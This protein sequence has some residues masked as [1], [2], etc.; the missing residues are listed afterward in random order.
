MK[1]LNDSDVKNVKPNAVQVR[2][3]MLVTKG[4]GTM[5]TKEDPK[6]HILSVSYNLLPTTITI[7]DAFGSLMKKDAEYLDL[8]KNTYY[9]GIHIWDSNFM[10]F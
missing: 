4:L 1:E 6:N 9:H 5:T 7:Q 3:V 10:S 8:V 2:T